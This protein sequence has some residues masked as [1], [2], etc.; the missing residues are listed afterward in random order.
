MV[1]VAPTA[2]VEG[3]A[4]RAEEVIA[5]GLATTMLPMYDVTT[6][7][8]DALDAVTATPAGIVPVEVAVK[9]EAVPPWQEDRD[10]EEHTV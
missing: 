8:V 7:E 2:T 1:T 5:N 4:E 9:V 10:C 6:S 3:D